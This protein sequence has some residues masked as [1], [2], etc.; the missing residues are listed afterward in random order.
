[1]EKPKLVTYRK[2]VVTNIDRVAS[3]VRIMHS[4][5][6]VNTKENLRGLAILARKVVRLLV[7]T[8]ELMA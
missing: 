2:D 7:S 8:R 6:V 3:S 5:K 4:G 1:M